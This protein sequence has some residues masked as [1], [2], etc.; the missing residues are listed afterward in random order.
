MIR[1]AAA[2]RVAERRRPTLALALDLDALQELPAEEEQA[3]KCGITCTG[4]CQYTCHQ[5]G[6]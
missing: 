1:V 6:D 5:T 4:T 2:P 3:G